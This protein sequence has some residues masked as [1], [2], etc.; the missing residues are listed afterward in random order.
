V[1]VGNPRQIDPDH[2]SERYG[3]VPPQ[4]ARACRLSR[5]QRRS[6]GC[7]A[8]VSG[9]AS[10]V[11][12]DTRHVDDLARQLDE[13]YANLVMLSDE[14]AGKRAASSTDALAR[15]KALRVYI[16]RPT[17]DAAVSSWLKASFPQI[18][19][20]ERVRANLCRPDLLVEVEGVLSFPD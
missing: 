8:L 1:P 12:E 6:L 14:L 3:P 19:D 15:Y 16:P 9:T 20:P 17:D 4:F 2:Y 10:I 11:G 7:S 18:A 5:G 13:V